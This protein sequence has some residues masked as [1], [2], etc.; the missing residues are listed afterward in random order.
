MIC[1]ALVWNT[2]KNPTRLTF[3]SCRILGTPNEET[4][5]GVTSLPD[6]KSAFPKWPAKV[7]WS[8]MVSVSLAANIPQL[9]IST[10]NCCDC[11][12]I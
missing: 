1:S 10:F 11:L 3:L 6:F 5:P 9:K 8:S 4:W 7:C 2:L 12:Q